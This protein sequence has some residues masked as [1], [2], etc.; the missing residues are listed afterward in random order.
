MLKKEEIFYLQM[1]IV[2]IDLKIIKFTIFE[3]YEEIPPL[4]FERKKLK[5]KLDNKLLKSH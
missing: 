4:K 1:A 3:K 2:D 5:I